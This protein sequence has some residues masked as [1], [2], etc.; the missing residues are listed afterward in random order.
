MQEV[1]GPAAT[2]PQGQQPPKALLASSYLQDKG[3]GL[4]E[5]ESA[6][7]ERGHKAIRLKMQRR[8]GKHRLEQVLHTCSNHHRMVKARIVTASQNGYNKANARLWHHHLTITEVGEQK[9][10]KSF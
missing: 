4:E 9:R 2:S 8:R 1:D 5:Y 3:M 6:E 7:R 10:K